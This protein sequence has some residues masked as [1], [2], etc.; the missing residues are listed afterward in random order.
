MK[1]TIRLLCVMLV[2]IM[3]FSIGITAHASGAEPFMGEVIMYAFDYA[4][5]SWAFTEGQIMNISGNSAL[6]SLL[7]PAF[8]GNGSTT[9]A[10][11]DLRQDTPGENLKMHYSIALNGYFPDLGNG[12]SDGILS[13]VRLFPLAASGRYAA[14]KWVRCDGGTLLVSSN[15]VLYSLMGNTYGGDDTHLG[16]P[17]LRAVEPEKMG[18][19]LCVNGYYGLDLLESEGMLGEM[20]LLAGQYPSPP[21]TAKPCDGLLLSI[22]QNSAL[23]SLLGT[24]YGG[25]GMHNFALPNTC[26]AGGD[27]SNLMNPLPGMQYYIFTEGFFPM[28]N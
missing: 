21:D 9:F 13:E 2:L 18:Y 16:L 1:K 4:P 14:N 27:D 5:W 28:R 11:P 3:T 7:G 6:F 12:V 26:A 8:G 19:Y 25:N 17:D 22:A 20:R 23:F 15:S 10:L 24:T